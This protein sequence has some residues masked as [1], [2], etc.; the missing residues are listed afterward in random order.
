MLPLPTITHFTYTWKFTLY[1]MKNWQV[2]E[3]MHHLKFLCSFLNLVL[4]MYIFIY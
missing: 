2:A 4:F 3:I 1:F